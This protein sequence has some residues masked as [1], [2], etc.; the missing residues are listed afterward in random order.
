MAKY[1]GTKNSDYFDGTPGN[2]VFLDISNGDWINGGDGYDTATIRLGPPHGTTTSY[3]QA[4]SGSL[5]GFIGNAFFRGIEDLAVTLSTGRD[6]VAFLQIDTAPIPK[7]SVDGGAGYDKLSIGLLFGNGSTVVQDTSGTVR[8]GEAIFTGFESI[9]VG[10]SLQNDTYYLNLGNSFV[11]I[12]EEEDGGFDTVVSTYGMLMPDNIERLI[13]NGTEQMAAFGNSLDNVIFGNEGDTTLDGADGNDT[14]V[15][16]QGN[17]QLTGGR[18]ADRLLGG[19]GNDTLYGGAGDDLINGGDGDDILIGGPGLNSLTGGTGKDTFVL[20]PPQD[21]FPSLLPRG[22]II[23]AKI[24]DFTRGEDQLQL[25]PEIFQAFAG[26]TSGSHPDAAALVLGTRAMTA[27][28]HLIYDKATGNLFYDAD[29]A[30]DTV[31]VLLAT[32]ANKPAVISTSDIVL[33]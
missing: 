27:D 7:L 22:G 25:S 5:E 20:E 3:I 10:G 28:Q 4:G 12:D 15:G 23:P 29:G 16:G 32:L 26:A 11:S 8:V 2:D 21:R 24:G 9:V 19:T 18:G 31:Q 14:I 33:G 17:D 13:L 30:G 1:R 6:V